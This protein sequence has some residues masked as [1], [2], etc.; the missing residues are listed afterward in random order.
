MRGGL[1]AIDPEKAAWTPVAETSGKPT[2]YRSTLTLPEQSDL[3]PQPMYRVRFAGLS[4]GTMWLNGHNLGRYPERIP[5]DGIYLPEC[6]LK[7]GDNRLVIFDEEGRSPAKVVVYAEFLASREV[8]RLSEAVDAATPIVLPAGRVDPTLAELNKGNL[9][10]QKKATASSSQGG[11]HA[12]NACDG[13]T[14]TRWCAA[15]GK[16]G[17]WWQVDLR[18]PKEL[19]GCELVWEKDRTRYRYLVEGSADGRDWIPLSDQRQTEMTDQTQKLNFSA[20]GIR[21]VRVTITQLAPGVWASL[22]EVR[23]LGR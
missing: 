21:Y 3:G 18:S 19:L 8:L 23:V 9:A 4:R 1:G 10:F 17:A 2:F 20:K 14:Q 16:A 11:N 6:W 13:E 22:N 12:G 7:G 5:I 15:D